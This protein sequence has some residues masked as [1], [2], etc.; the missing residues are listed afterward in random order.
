VAVLLPRITDFPYTSWFLRCTEDNKAILEVVGKRMEFRFVLTGSQMEF[1]D[2]MN[3]PELEHLRGLKSTPGYI[4]LELKKSG[5]LLLPEDRDAETCGVTPKT[6]EAEEMAIFNMSLAARTLA[7]CNTKWNNALGQDIVGVRWRENLEYDE[8][9]AEND[10]ADW[11]SVGFWSNKCA[12]MNIKESDEEVNK[13]IP[14]EHVTHLSFELAL[15]DNCT[16][17][18]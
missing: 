15:L 8:T 3:I 13:E 2:S 7:F 6:A 16:P 4:V 1:V 18:A 10:E 9:F 11:N 14:E 17:A 12:L 5:I